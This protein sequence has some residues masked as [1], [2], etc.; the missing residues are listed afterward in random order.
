MQGVLSAVAIDLDQA[1]TDR[2]PDEIFHLD[3][4]ARFD[5]AVD[6]SLGSDAGDVDRCEMLQELFT[7]KPGATEVRF[8]LEKKRDFSVI[9]DVT[10]KVRPDKEF[11]AEVTRICGA[12]ALEILAS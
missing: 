12:E 2:N 7:K 5:M 1:D 9:L 3:A 8:R 11:K 6:D 4:I 10:A